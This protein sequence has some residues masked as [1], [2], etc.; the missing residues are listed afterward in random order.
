MKQHQHYHTVAKAIH[1]IVDNY[2]TQPSLEEIA[3]HVHLS[4]YHF[5]RLFQQW[6]GVSP[7]Q[8][9]QHTTVQHAKQRLQEGR[10]TLA[11]AYD[12]GLSGTGRL[13]D[14]FVKIEAC[15]PGEFK[16][17]GLGLL[18]QYGEID[19]PFG[20]AVIAETRVGIC[21]LHFI[22]DGDDPK[23]FVHAAFDEAVL[24]PELG[25]FGEL[26]EQYFVTW[27]QPKEQI[28]LDL[29]GTPFQL[30]VWRALLTI[31]AAQ[32]L[33]YNDI[34]QLIDKPKAVRAVGTAIGK[35]P[36]A[37]LIPCHRVIRESGQLGG[38]RWGLDRKQLINGYEMVSLV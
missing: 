1:F 3:E 7:K 2:H 17:R 10:S 11:T 13:H 20:V 5:Q 34:A 21:L 19:T 31:P 37:Y 36:I 14:L 28:V 24:V 33:A 26:V 18:I 4:K 16:K 8:F 30:S 35:N 22:E 32:L 27:K 15:T 23:S 29:K 38:Y 9:L 6:A 25:K 12:V